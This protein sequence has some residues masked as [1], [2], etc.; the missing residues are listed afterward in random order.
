MTPSHSEMMCEDAQVCAELPWT[1]GCYFGSRMSRPRFVVGFC[2][3]LTISQVTVPPNTTSVKTHMTLLS[4]WPHKFLNISAQPMMKRLRGES[5][6][7]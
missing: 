1:F 6:L 5:F 7:L 3:L 2:A 4:G